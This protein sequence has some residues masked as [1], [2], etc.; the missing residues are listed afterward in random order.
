[1]GKRIDVKSTRHYDGR[2]LATLKENGGAAGLGRRSLIKRSL[3]LALGLVGLS[4][5][6]LL[7]DLGPQPKE[8]LNK[9]DWAAGTG[10]RAHQ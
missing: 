4:P 2:L 8:F 9:T 1:M 10:K 6:V 3:G 5:L 7:R